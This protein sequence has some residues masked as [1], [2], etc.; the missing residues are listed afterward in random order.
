MT[1][2]RQDFK[3]KTL[4][5]EA[6]CCRHFDSVYYVYVEEEEVEEGQVGET[7]DVLFVGWCIAGLGRGSLY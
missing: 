3:L 5:L 7:E 6:L 2:Q 4:P 1:F